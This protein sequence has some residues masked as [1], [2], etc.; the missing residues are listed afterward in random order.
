MKRR[1][2]VACAA[3]MLAAP[4][5]AEVRVV[6]TPRPLESA[7]AVFDRRSAS[8]LQPWLCAVTNA[9]AEVV[10]VSEAALLGWTM[11]QGVS[12][13]SV[14]EIRIGAAEIKRRGKWATTG[15]VLA[16]AGLVTAALAAGDV[17]AIGPAWGSVAGFTALQLPQLGEKLARRDPDG[18]IFERL[19]MP[20]ESA[21]APG[22]S[23]MLRVFAAA[24]KQAA[25][26][27]G[28]LDG[29]AVQG[30]GTGD[31]GQE[32][33]VFSALAEA[34]A[35]DGREPRRCAELLWEREMAR[36]GAGAD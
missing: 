36:V 31:K 27:E 15:R 34:D 23:V 28:V 19:A 2:R 12:P 1:W 8:A 29:F 17:I 14:D 4:L 16:Y 24:D 3:L 30:Q 22:E 5:T 6:C 26:I 32:E 7:R 20:A 33:P 25:K 11:R 9:G 21:L 10:T 35:C 18:A 13:Y